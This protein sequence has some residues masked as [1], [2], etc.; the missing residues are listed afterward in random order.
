MGAIIGVMVIGLAIVVFLLGAGNNGSTS[1]QQAN[2]ANSAN[3]GAVL[4]TTAAP[5]STGQTA[6][7]DPPR[8]PL[9][10]FKALYDD[11]AK[12]PMIID[13]RPI[14]AYNQGHIK[15]A[16]SFPED[17]VDA[18]INELPKDKLVV[19]YCQ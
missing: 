15:G 10:D 14:D 8:M 7:T 12:R 13:V 5:G 4:P 6:G 9:A 3:G 18:R 16:I 1:N 2:G 17:S 19:A 11:P